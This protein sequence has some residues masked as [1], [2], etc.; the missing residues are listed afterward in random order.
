M[1]KAFALMPKKHSKYMAGKTISMHQIKQIIELLSKNYSVRSI[2]RLSGISRNTIRD[3]R[4]RIDRSKIS[5]EELLKL[6]NET[7]S[8]LLER[9][10][11]L[12]QDDS[13]RRKDFENRLDYFFSELR[14]RGVTR[15]LL[16]D[17]YRSEN[18]SGYGYSQFCDH[19][20]KELKIKNAVMHFTHTPGEQMMVDF[21]GDT[22]HYIDRSTGEIVPCQIL[23]CVLPYS[24]YTYVEALRSQKQDEFV[25]GL[26]N[27]LHYMGGVPQSIKCDNLR[28]AVTKA[29]RYEPTF[30]EAMDFFAQHYGL[31]VMAARVRK[32][33]DKASVESAVSITYKRIYAPLRDQVF[34]S[35]AE[36]N[37][38]IRIQL[39]KHHAWNFKGKD[40]SRKMIFESEEKQLL[41]PLPENRYVIKHTAMAKV[42]KNYHLIL[43][44]DFHQ[45]SVP[46]TLIGETVKLIYTHDLV[47]V[48]HEH[49]RVAFHSRNY[50]KY[51][52][53]T[54][55]SHMPANHLHMYER[56]GWNAETFI[57]RAETI[58]PSAKHFIGRILTSKVFPEQTFNSCLGIFRLGK[59]YGTE[60]LEAA[61]KR[62]AESPYANY[63]IIQNILKN[64]LDK[65][66]QPEI[67][68]IP[69]HDNI[70]GST[71]YQ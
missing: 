47:E 40:Y 22:L 71:K 39:E 61:C 7:L 66:I 15:Q 17:E 55:Q 30:T 29:N 5:F 58:G 38:A 1:Q 54:L 4:L 16:W 37:H 56:K 31:T 2:V 43:G 52:Y 32:P 24:N 34:Y 9:K 26:S 21:A 70:R 13:D 60:R 63:G 69:D 62:A 3:Y 49:K 64:N 65:T 45:Y 68:F 48:Y 41:K 18:P 42:Q 12:P 8:G 27:A 11:T 57:N 23:V 33:R 51:G 25:S 28:S 14:R 6:D 50:K 20:S 67:N 59:Q 46:Y 44:E 19:L 10:L 35:L 53:T 36:L